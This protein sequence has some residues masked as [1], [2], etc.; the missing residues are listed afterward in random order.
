MHILKDGASFVDW[1]SGSVGNHNFHTGGTDLKFLK[2][3]NCF[4]S[5]K[6]VHP[7]ESKYNIGTNI[8]MKLFILLGYDNV[9]KVAHGEISVE[10][11]LEMIKNKYG[12]EKA[13]KIIDG[14]LHYAGVVE[15]KDL[16]ER[17]IV[18]LEQTMLE[19]MEENIKKLDCREDVQR[20]FN[21]YYI[22]K[23]FFSTTYEEEI[24][25]DWKVISQTDY[26]SKKINYSN[27]EEL[28]I[29]KIKQYNALPVFS[30]DEVMNDIALKSFFGIN[31]T[32]YGGPIGL[33]DEL[34]TYSEGNNAGTLKYKNTKVTFNR[35]GQIDIDASL[36]F[37]IT[38]GQV[39]M[40]LKPVVL[41]TGVTL[42]KSTADLKIGETLTL[43]ATISPSNASN[44]ELIW[45]SENTSVA[46]VSNGVVTAKGA[47][48]AT[49]TATA[50][51]GSGE[52][53]TCT[54]TVTKPVV[55][56]T[57]V[58]LNKNTANLN[59]GE[60]LT[61]TATVSPSN[62]SN[63]ELTW[64][65]NNTSVATVSNG[66]VTA[67]GVGTATITATA[68]DGSGQ[69]ATC[70]VTVTKLATEVLSI[71]STKY[72]IT[73]EK[74][75]DYIQYIL[76]ETTI[77]TVFEN[78]D[79]NAT[80]KEVYNGTEKIT[81]EKENVGTGMT[82]KFKKG[83]EEKTYIVVVKGDVSGDGKV[84]FKD[85]IIRVN[86]HRLGGIKLLNEKLKAAD[87]V[88]DGKIEFK[89]IV[90]INKLRLNSLK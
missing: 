2:D 84:T 41:V 56:V 46:T 61:L 31:M 72:K 42:N 81:D 7:G 27:I 62:V 1:V 36:H 10:E 87:L 75:Q 45:A 70:T 74:N 9:M 25:D 69:K 66:V 4:F 64:T 55:L 68:T 20:Y 37:D 44:K 90:E 80:I 18:D 50:T 86:Q 22:Y 71:E 28:L 83:T 76:P 11:S 16:T 51:D 85:D 23:K 38:S 3:G 24:V 15:T 49:I 39:L 40:T 73:T 89:D 67:K 21:L 35:A 29:N 30:T 59:I 54:V 53:A 13:S 33:F 78:I 63:K 12:E 77:K 6:G 65:S 88:M 5:I 17:Q 79:T 43:G 58:T 26:T 60:T 19:I 32:K 57:G 82:I 34:Y 52:K 14:L 48:T 8:Y 47:G